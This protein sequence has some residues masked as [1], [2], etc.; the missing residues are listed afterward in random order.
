VTGEGHSTAATDRRADGTVRQALAV[1]MAS[2]VVV[3]LGLGLVG[4]LAVHE[5]TESVDN[6]TRQVSPAQVA[7]AEFMETMLDA[8]TELRAYLI[9]GEPDQLADHRSALARVP[10]AEASLEAYAAQHHDIAALVRLQDTRADAWIRD[11]VRAAITEGPDLADHNMALFDLGVRR[12][13]AVKSVNQVI[14]D[15]L[16]SQVNDARADAQ[17]R[18]DETVTLIAVLGLLGAL[19]CGFLGWRAIRRIRRPL[20]Q[21]SG[22]VDRLTA[23][24]YDARADITGPAEIA[25][26]AQA[27]NQMADEN[28]RARDVE[29]Q[30]QERLLEVDKVKSEFV[31]NVSHELRT[32]LT[33]ISGYLE[34]LSEDL[35]DRIDPEHAEMMQVMRRNSARLGTLIEDLLDL[36]RVERE[37][38]RLRSVDVGRLVEDV[39][40]DLRL[41]A[42]SR[43]VSITLDLDPEATEPV[44]LADQAQLHRALLNVLSNAVKFSHDG[45][46]VLMRLGTTDSQVEVTVTDTGIGIPS[47]DQHK[48]GERFYRASNAVTAH[49]PGT[50]LG[51]RMVQ[52]IV[53]H[54]QGTFG[55][56]SQ[57]G[58]GTTATMR[59]PLQRVNGTPL[60][61][62]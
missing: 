23:G 11:F 49:I 15:R 13:D 25:G 3:M 28:A 54:H 55:L 34:L 6:L 2:A 37:P 42:G 30:V 7:N 31:A 41:S 9:S 52:A 51:L 56:S 46:D 61:P 50:G 18:L 20:G 19:I 58:V 8:E 45:G 10:S 62:A 21:L 43:D 24:E 36:G 29:Q 38:D 22:V 16:E 32:P 1:V 48:V 17:S 57:E 33:S 53:S 59:L 4:A 39:A 35:K 14:D 60:T 26:L 27:I 44:V 5:S 12:F 47:G 40:R